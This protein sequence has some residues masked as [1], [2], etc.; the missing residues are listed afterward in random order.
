MIK[1]TNKNTLKRALG[2]SQHHRMSTATGPGVDEWGT[3]VKSVAASADLTW[4]SNLKNS[5]KYNK[6]F[7]ST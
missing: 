5:Q 2:V 7:T 6:I 4:A 3:P 1:F